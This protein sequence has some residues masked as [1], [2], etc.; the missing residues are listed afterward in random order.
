MFG[1]YPSVSDI[2]RSQSSKQAHV[3]AMASEYALYTT[4]LLGMYLSQSRVISPLDVSLQLKARLT[5]M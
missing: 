3:F 1:L 2:F 4:N 5:A